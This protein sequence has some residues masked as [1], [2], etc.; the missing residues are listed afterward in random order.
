M[1]QQFSLVTDSK[2]HF[3]TNSNI[4][5]TDIAKIGWESTSSSNAIIDICPPWKFAPDG[6]CRI[7]CTPKLICLFRQ[8]I[9]IKNNIFFKCFFSWLARPASKRRHLAWNGN[10]VCCVSQQV[11][12]HVYL[13][14]LD[15]MCVFV[16]VFVTVCVCVTE[17]MP[18]SLEETQQ[19]VL[20]FLARRDEGFDRCLKQYQHSVNGGVLN[21][22][23]RGEYKH[24]I[25]WW[26]QRVYER[27]KRNKVQFGPIECA[28]LYRL[29]DMFFDSSLKWERYCAP[30]IAVYEFVCHL[31]DFYLGECFLDALMKIVFELE[32]EDL[33]SNKSTCSPLWEAAKAIYRKHLREEKEELEI[34]TKF[35]REKEEQREQKEAALQEEA[36]SQRNIQGSR[37]RTG[38][39]FKRGGRKW[40]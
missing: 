15:C 26:L 5:I 32:A 23:D 3:I 4:T 27:A 35:E 22:V 2:I 8:I 11:C 1:V 6:H 20:D 9:I 16:C 18:H 25:D 36:A 7:M 13:C 12:S 31:E 40:K 17:F 33:S 28:T 14:V 39:A 24:Q 37:K 30:Q 21:R 34:K 10:T 19:V 29:M 38:L